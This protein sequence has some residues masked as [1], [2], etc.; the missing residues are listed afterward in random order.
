MNTAPISRTTS[1]LA[2][3]LLILFHV[4]ALP[5]AAQTSAPL[6]YPAASPALQTFSG[7]AGSA[8][9]PWVEDLVSPYGTGK[10]TVV[11]EPGNPANTILKIS[12][13]SQ[14]RLEFSSGATP[15]T[16]VITSFRFRTEALNNAASP[17]TGEFG[18][19][20]GSVFGF[21]NI[22]GG[23]NIE[24][25]HGDG[26]GGGVWMSTGKSVSPANQWVELVIRQDFTAKTWDLWIRE[27]GQMKLAAY[28]LGLW[29]NT[30]STAQRLV[31]VGFLTPDGIA[32]DL[33]VDDVG[34]AGSAPWDTD[35]DGVPDA[36]ETTHGGITAG[37]RARIAQVAGDA[38][39]SLGAWAA[40]ANSP[41]VPWW[42]RRNGSLVVTMTNHEKALDG[43][44][45]GITW[46]EASGTFF[47]IQNNSGKRIVELNRSGQLLKTVWT[48]GDPGTAFEDPEGITWI[49]PVAGG[50]VNQF[51]IAEERSRAIVIVTVGPETWSPRVR[52]TN[53]IP[54]TGIPAGDDNKGLEGICHIT[55]SS[56][57]EF[58]GI[59]EGEPGTSNPLAVLRIA[60]DGVA[61]PVPGLPADLHQ[62]LND[63]ADIAY[64]HAR[65]RLYLLSEQSRKILI[66][67]LPGASGTQTLDLD[68][69]AQTPFP[70]QPEGL[71]LIPGGGFA[72]VG[73]PAWFALYAPS[74]GF[75]SQSGPYLNEIVAANNTGILDREGKARDWIEIYNPAAVPVSLSGANLTYTEAG[76]A[77]ISA[78]LDGLVLQPREHRVLFASAKSNAQFTGAAG[79]EFHLPFKLKAG[80]GTLSLTGVTPVS[81]C[82]WSGLGADLAYGYANDAPSAYAILATPTPGSKNAGVAVSPPLAVPAILHN[83]VAPGSLIVSGG[84]ITFTLAGNPAGTLLFYT[85]DGTEPYP[86]NPSLMQWNG[87]ALPVA[88]TMLVRAAAHLP[89]ARPSDSVSRAF[90]SAAGVASQGRPAGPP[91][92]NYPEATDGS[93]WAGFTPQTGIVYGVDTGA[94]AAEQAAAI[95]AITS[96]APAL[97]LLLDPQDLFWLTDGVYANSSRND[98]VFAVERRAA[99]EYYDPASPTAGRSSLHAGLK[100]SGH[101]S[102]YW[103]NTPKH[104]FRLHFRD[105]YG[106]SAF[107]RSGLFPAQAGDPT[108]VGTPKYEVLGLRSP[109]HDSFAVGGQWAPFRETAKYITDTWVNKR[110]A[111]LATP[112]GTQPFLGFTPAMPDAVRLPVPHRRWVNVF[113]NGL[114]WGVYELIENVDGE[115]A[116]QALGKAKYDVLKS[117]EGGNTPES[118]ADAAVSGSWGAWTNGVKSR[119]AVISGAITSTA[120]EAAFLTATNA[121]F[122]DIKANVDL[123]SLIDYMLL[124]L[125]IGNSD[126]P[127]HNYV[128]VRRRIQGAPGAGWAD[129]RFRFLSWDAEYGLRVSPQNDSTSL[130]WLNGGDGPG[131]LFSVLCARSDFRALVTI[132][133]NALLVDD[134]EGTGLPVA[135]TSSHYRTMAPL[136]MRSSFDLAV[137]DFMGLT[138]S[139]PEDDGLAAAE[140]LRWGKVFTNSQ[141]LPI[142][143]DAAKWRANIAGSRDNF[144][145]QRTAA[146]RSHMG[147]FLTSVEGLIQN[148]RLAGAGGTGGYT[149]NTNG[150]YLA[151]YGA[152]GIVIGDAD[153]DGI[154]DAWETG[155]NRIIQNGPAVGF[156]VFSKLHPASASGS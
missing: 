102:R 18:E 96:K 101:S 6:P 121:A 41:P 100:I 2:F 25:L 12:D 142:K 93:S 138:G 59:I 137:R 150:G 32:A 113:I 86:D 75:T 146:M 87:A 8:I 140:S 11:A 114:Y 77:P 85:L 129:G 152:T 79:E 62:Q 21:L 30:A 84:S 19:S 58:Y 83:G 47:A 34:V 99:L 3:T 39:W 134:P 17:A 132:R 127:M 124:N 50:P 7:Y 111:E 35:A 104:S 23:G 143:Y 149:G 151:G 4:G 136:A 68:T 44:L 141:N 128:M 120:T 13:G 78:V 94:S 22:G 53:I 126:W 16:K 48:S 52:R 40:S 116:D 36:W 82:A 70:G 54:V 9:A 90:I 28:D 14:A 71:A 156:K 45:S 154:P 118:L 97:S 147:A 125:Y 63:L 31:F 27:A 105:K 95:T 60:A 37:G 65:Q 29:D 51:A 106:A 98:G 55:G 61:S 112:Q 24:V 119:A 43:D 133:A 76:A 155:G 15:P 72:V 107:Q 122:N 144:F 57:P 46:N 33:F 139:A 67:P 5:C 103:S 109:M 92:G 153:G 89:G 1:A 108:P 64:D 26:S 88:G 80:G 148:I 115:F 69:A 81:N 110:L 91:L 117:P 38:L 123:A 56:P 42:T 73:E 20:S 131:W 130:V 145:P 49:K 66:L 135:P 10:V 74:T